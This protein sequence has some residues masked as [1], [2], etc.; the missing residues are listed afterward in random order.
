MI[1]VA[2]ALPELA[3]EDHGGGDLHIAVLFVDLAP[4]VDQGVAQDHALGQEEG[5][6]GAFVG[7]HEQAQLLA[8]L[9]VVALLGLLDALEVLIQ[10]FLFHKAGAVNALERLA[11]GVAP[12]VRAVAGSELD[13]VAL[14]PAG[15][16]QMGAGAEVGKVALLIEADDGVLG[17][18]LDQLHLIGLVPL[19]HEFDGL[20]PGQLKA[21]QLDLL[22]ADLAHLRFQL[23]QDLRSDGKGGVEI[24][25]EAV[26]DG[27][28]DGQLYLGVQAFHGLGQNVAGGVAVGVF[29]LG[30]FKG[31][32]IFFVHSYFSSLKMK[33]TPGIS[34]R[35]PELH[36]STLN[37][38]SLGA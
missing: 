24:I 18:I 29:I 9:A 6:A 16:V 25:V 22:L 7:E 31:I 13:G 10:L 8:D 12:P 34:P 37:F 21:L 11:A 30:I 26:F 4:V 1:P 5:E 38:H 2:A 32:Q 27:R 20:F 33:G 19:L 36:G 28:A 3:V 23:F 35:V 14:D 15:G 17:Q